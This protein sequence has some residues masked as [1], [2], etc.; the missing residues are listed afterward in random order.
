MYQLH[1]NCRDNG[2]GSVS[3]QFHPDEKSAEKADR[4]NEGFGESTANYVTL[5]VENNKLFRRHCE[6][7]FEKKKL[8]EMW[9]E[10]KPTNA[11]V[12]TNK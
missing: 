4:E 1:Y 7:N 2:D 11:N 3:V 12:S 5:K 10:I 6:Y 9:L 8:E